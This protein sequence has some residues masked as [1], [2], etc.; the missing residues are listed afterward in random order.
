MIKTL[1]SAPIILISQ[2]V[3][4][5]EP[6]NETRDSLDQTLSRWVISVNAIPL[7]I[8][9]TLTSDKVIA[10]LEQIK[11]TG[12]LLSGGNNVGE[13][14]DRDKTEMCLLDWAKVNNVPVLG[15][16]RGMQ[17]IATWSGVELIPVA[18]HVAGKHVINGTLNASVNS[19]H[20]YA[21]KEVPKGFNAL[22][23]TDDGCLE[24]ICSNSEWEC[25]GWMWHPEREFPFEQIWL[26]RFCALMKLN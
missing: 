4:Y 25:E 20:D 11:P 17:L 16:C 23:Y 3:D 22:A 21:L 19:Y 26:D 14:S 8:P 18:G 10:L 6:R 15:L 7:S 9:N 1:V 12:I 2:R 24:A 5:I 13:F